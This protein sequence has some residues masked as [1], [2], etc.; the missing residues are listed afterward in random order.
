VLVLALCALRPMTVAELCQ[1]LGRRDAKELRRTH[2][3]P[4][5]AEGLLALKYPETE[6]HPHQAYLS[7]PDDQNKKEPGREA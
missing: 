7:V 4:L 3:R 2:L 6:K 1:A 5:R